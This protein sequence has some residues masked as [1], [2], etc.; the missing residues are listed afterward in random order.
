MDADTIL[1]HL[2]QLKDEE[3]LRFRLTSENAANSLRLKLFRKKKA[4]TETMPDIARRIQIIYKRS[5]MVVEVKMTPDVML[6]EKVSAN[7]EVSLI[8]DNSET[9][10]IVALMRQ[11]GA[12]EEEINEFIAAGTGHDN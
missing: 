7:G 8:T 5:Q 10:R 1:Q 6:V 2:L 3:L 12:T 9:D 11:D 4:L